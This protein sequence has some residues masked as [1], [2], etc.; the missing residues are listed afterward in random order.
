MSK[1]RIRFLF[2]RLRSKSGQRSKSCY[3]NK[4]KTTEA[5][6]MKHHRKIKYNE[7]VC[8]AQELGSYA[9]GQGHNT[10][11]VQIAPKIRSE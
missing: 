10:A 2:R 11:R 9:K 3:G 1:T 6:L 8:H 5:N 4:S 7:K